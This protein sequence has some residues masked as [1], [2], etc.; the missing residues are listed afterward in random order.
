MEKEAQ[1]RKAWIRAAMQRY[2]RPLTGYALRIT[3]DL[4]RA[5]D[6]VQDTF[7]RLCSQNPSEIGDRL[8]PWLFTVCRRRSIDV[9]R[10]EGRFNAF[11]EGQL[12]AQ[13]SP[14]P[15]P[16]VELE[17]RESEHLILSH[18][19]A[20]PQQQQEVL[21][22]KFQNELTY[23]EI[24]EVTGLSASNVGFLIHRGM[25]ALRKKMPASQNAPEARSPRLRK[26]Q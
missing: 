16:A 6:V 24:S 15:S 19:S 2:E 14:D 7:L 12:E 3:R 18:L 10:K 11:E 22:L 26:V 21:R 9:L 13:P 4:E 25:C 8:A 1:H 5:R 20:L 17:R 23:R